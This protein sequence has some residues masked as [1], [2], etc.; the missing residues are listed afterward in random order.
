MENLE[1]IDVPVAAPDAEAMPI[2]PATV[3]DELKK[4]AQEVAEI[5]Q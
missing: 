3:Q 4:V 1:K 5:N 2:D